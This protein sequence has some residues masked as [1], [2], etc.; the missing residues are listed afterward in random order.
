[1]FHGRRSGFV[2]LPLTFGRPLF[3][4]LPASLPL[5]SFCRSGV[6]LPGDGLNDELLVA[7]DVRLKEDHAG[8]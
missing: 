1:M 7:V 5:G 2:D 6:S 3:S 4:L 8:E